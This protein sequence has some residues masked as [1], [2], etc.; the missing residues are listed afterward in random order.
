[1]LFPALAADGVHKTADDSDD[2]KI[3]ARA[4]ALPWFLVLAAWFVDP[5]KY[6]EWFLD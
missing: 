6:V 2:A 3:L 4:L 1:M 5:R